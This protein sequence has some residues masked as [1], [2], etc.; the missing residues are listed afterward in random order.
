MPTR[1]ARTPACRV[2][3]HVDTECRHGKHKCL[4]HITLLLLMIAAAG[5]QQ[6]P[7]GTN[8]GPKPQQDPARDAALKQIIPLTTG[9]REDDHPAVAAR[10]GRIWMAWVSFSETEGT[11]QIYA[12]AMEHGR[13]SEPVPVS[14][15]PGDYHKPALT[16][17]DDGAVWIAWPAQVRGNWD[18]Y[19]RVGRAGAWSKTEQWST[20][21]GPDM[22]PQLAAAKGRVMLVWQALRKNSLDI[23]YRVGAGQLGPEGYVTNN[24]AND[25]EPVLAASAD[26]SFHVAWDSYRG[27]YDVFL[28]TFSGDRW[29]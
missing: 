1:G 24:A 29:S 13:W 15:T 14:E 23:L 5:A 9:V 22:A 20:D 21:P 27:D 6:R 26:G 12:R 7:L 2:D 4:R 8:P 10:D 11:S 18:I 28:R 19:G 16:I 17:A 3:T 25:W